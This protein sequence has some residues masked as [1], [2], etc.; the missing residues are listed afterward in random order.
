[1]TGGEA[2]G[3]GG[4]DGNLMSREG[5]HLGNGREISRCAGDIDSGPNTNQQ[6]EL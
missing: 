5:I 4:L 1:M 2:D 3:E 6:V